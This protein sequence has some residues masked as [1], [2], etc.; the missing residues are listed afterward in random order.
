MKVY[1][2]Q[3]QKFNLVETI[4]FIVHSA[5]HVQLIKEGYGEALVAL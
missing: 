5:P 3:R 2:M 4:L 1:D